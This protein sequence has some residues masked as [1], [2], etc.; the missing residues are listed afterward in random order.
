MSGGSRLLLSPLVTK[1][2]HDRVKIVNWGYRNML[3]LDAP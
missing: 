3:A 2:R 1:L